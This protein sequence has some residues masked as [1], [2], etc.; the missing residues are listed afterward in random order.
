MKPLPLFAAVLLLA[1]SP[2]A[3]GQMPTA[4]HPHSLSLNV[5]ATSTGSTAHDHDNTSDKRAFEHPGVGHE[6]YRTHQTET[7]KQSESV[8]V[9]VRNFGQ[10]P[11][12]VQVEWYFVAAPAAHNT[13]DK[14]FIYDQGTKSV[15][16]APGATETFPVDS[17]E[18]ASQIKRH[19]QVHLDKKGNF[20]SEHSGKEKEVGAVLDGWM[21][22][23]VADGRALDAKASKDQLMD[24][25]KDDAKLQAMAAH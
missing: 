3:F 10:L 13:L 14:Q 23:V 4:A 15:T 9:S 24:I 16:I 20:H 21:V 7:N 5:E 22:R 8:Q 25:V 1:G 6:E 18:I 2:S 11:D 17:K 12:T 19:N